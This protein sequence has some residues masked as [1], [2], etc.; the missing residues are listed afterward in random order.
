MN[1][2][3]STQQNSYFTTRHHRRATPRRQ[4]DSEYVPPATVNNELNKVVPTTVYSTE[5]ALLSGKTH[6]QIMSEIYAALK[7]LKLCPSKFL[8]ESTD[9]SGTV[10]PCFKLRHCDPNIIISGSNMVQSILEQFVY[11]HQEQVQELQEKI[12]V[13][14]EKI[15]FYDSMKE[16]KDVFNFGVAAKALDTGKVRLV[17][18]LRDHGILTAGG[19]KKNL[20]YQQHLDCGR[21][22]VEWGF[23][24]DSEGNRHLKPIILV[25]GK[26]L[27]WLK[28]Y[29][30]KHGR[31]GL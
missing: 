15:E 12:I 14:A 2:K 11:D 27:I 4:S 21:F 30:D 16:A 19:Y 8:A 23:Y 1:Q 18:Y 17:R 13:N 24:E 20:P 5:V 10:V 28:Q 3:Y 26:G 6:H 22:K 9:S 25:T 7:V 31:T 29:I